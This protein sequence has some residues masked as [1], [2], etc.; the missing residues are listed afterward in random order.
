MDVT[1]LL[2]DPGALTIRTF[3]SQSKAI[4]LIVESCQPQPR[5]PKCD[6]PS[7]SL[8]SHY[9]RTLADLPWHGIAFKL[10]LRTR[11]FR[12]KNPACQRKIFC[13]RLPHVAE[14]YARKSLRLNAALTILAFALG[15]E[16]GHRAAQRLGLRISGDSL[17]RRIRR[18][19]ALTMIEHL[20][21]TIGI[22][23]WARCKGQRYGTIIVDLQRRCPIDLLLDR[24]AGTVAA[25]LNAHPGI[26][27]VSR[28]RAGAYAEAVREGAPAA[29]RVADRWHLMKNAR[30]ALERLL[31]RQHR[32]LREAFLACHPET[33]NQ[34]KSCPL[35]ATQ[36]K[37]SPKT[38][39]NAS[40]QEQYHAE[41]RALFDLVKQLQQQGL[42]I[43]QIRLQLH[44]HHTTIARFFH[45][46]SYP[47]MQPPPRRRATFPYLDYL[48]QRWA[49][50][51]HNAAQLYQELRERGY[52]GSDVTVR[53]QTTKWRQPVPMLVEK[54]PPPR[55]MSWVLLKLADQ[56]TEEEKQRIEHLE[57][58][59]QAIQV[60]REL[61]RRF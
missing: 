58:K 39:S 57:S 47:E 29:T 46:E 59:S 5:C 52:R 43:N 13:E 40:R 28:D 22:D 34:Q 23:D 37:I 21:T 35:A 7:A 36:R 6:Q 32:A 24:E 19:Q 51:C 45:A 14:A 48:K 15:G 27:V 56:V 50:G 60:G 1:T 33:D 8:H 61:V 17:L 42:T 3:L 38:A 30:E 55:N 18:S 16:A 54:P 4:T 9:T 12:C 11:R 41:R 44:R 25:W 10:Q 53:R 49:E 26:E 31:Q 20:P 2:A